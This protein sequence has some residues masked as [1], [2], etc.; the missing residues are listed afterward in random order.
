M[1]ETPDADKAAR[2]IAENVYFAFSR[3]ATSFIH[4]AKEQILLTRLVEAIR[5]E[6]ASSQDMIVVAANDA[7]VAWEQAN[8]EVRGPRV[9]SLDLTDGSVTMSLPQQPD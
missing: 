1:Q 9:A 2:N 5:P 7:L 3:Q 8:D 4:P 6:I